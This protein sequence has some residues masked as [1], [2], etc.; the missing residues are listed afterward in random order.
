MDLKKYIADNFKIKPEIIDF[1][2]DCEKEV[3]SVFESFKM[4][5][6]A[7]Q[8][9][10]IDAFKNNN[11]ASR[12]FY[13]ST[14]YGYD[15]EG[16]E[17]L[18]RVF[19]DS[20]GAEHAIVSPLLMSGTHAISTA[21]F[22][23][24]RPNDTLFSL[25][26]KPYDTLLSTLYGASGSLEEYNIHYQDSPL[27]ENGKIDI[28]NALNLIDTS[29]KVVY[30][31]RSTGYEIRP[32]YTTQYL[33]TIIAQVKKQ[34]PEI[35]V[36]VDNCYGEFVCIDE[37]T[38]CG[39]NVIAGSL[40]KN[41]GGGIAP[42][43]GYI[44]GDT[45]LIEQ[46]SARFSCPGIG[47]EIGSYAFGYQQYFQGLFM[48][49]HTVSQALMGVALAARVFEQLG[50]ATQ[51][52]YNAVRGDITQSIIFGNENLLTDFIRGIQRASAVD[53]N[54]VPYAWDMPGY[55]DKVI[56]AAGTFVQGASIELTADAPI[57]EPY[58]A[59]LQGAL[60]YEHAKLGIL[61]ALDEMKVKL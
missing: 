17:R 23:L 54:V 40:I 18:Y 56:M 53:G 35:I 29:V 52:A 57:R 26:G 3:E 10:V 5:A 48:A 28:E 33:R 27:L 16:R 21:L 41:A 19:A 8:F 61:Y 6:Q 60:T 45:D 42:T 46:I 50:Y 13:A 36:M 30:I 47:T 44:A 4:T 11:V 38:Q 43:G 37:P 24:L 55:A 20:F 2:F 22:G 34:F 32:A 7:N 1:V 9:K 59:Y 14:G 49:P 31:Q 15:D 51:P 12:H 39:A 25:T 58:A